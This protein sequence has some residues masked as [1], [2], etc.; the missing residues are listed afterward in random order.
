MDLQAQMSTD[1]DQY[2]D[3]NLIPRS[4]EFDILHWWRG[5]SSK[6]PVLS[7]IARDVLAIL[8]SSIASEFAF[9]AEKRIISEFCS[10]FNTRNC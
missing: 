8:A 1:L 6:Y 9:S 3:E 2:L 10:S 5:N 7:Y 4:K